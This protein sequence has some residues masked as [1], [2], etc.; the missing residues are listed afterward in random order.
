M[1]DPVIGMFD[2]RSKHCRFKQHNSTT[3]RGGEKEYEIQVKK[4]LEP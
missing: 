1:I 2:D 3:K 4:N